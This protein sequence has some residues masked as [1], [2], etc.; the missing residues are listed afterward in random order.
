MGFFDLPILNAL[1]TR[2]QFH[3]QRQVVLAQNVAN[4]ETPG[5]GARDLK[6]PDFESLMSQANGA[7]RGGPMAPVRTSGAHLPGLPPHAGFGEVNAPDFETT[8]EGNS[9]VLE[10][11]MMKIAQNQIDH[12]IATTV[13][14]RGI[15]LMK[16]AVARSA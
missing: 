4:A 13:Y 8:P 10:D 1:R 12:Q 9:V 7:V 16:R 14:A 2:M 3:S 15:S 6:A 5:Y 11:E